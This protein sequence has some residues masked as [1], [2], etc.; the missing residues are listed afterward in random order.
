MG[1]PRSMKRSVLPCLGFLAL[2]FLFAGCAAS[3][4]PAG[5]SV[6]AVACR[7]A[8][9][10]ATLTLQYVNESVYA[11]GIAKSSHKLYLDG[12]PV[13]VIAAAPAVGLP[14]VKS[15]SQDVIIHFDDADRVRRL[16]ASPGAAAVRYRLE[17][18]LFETVGEEDYK[19]K[20]HSEGSLDLRPLAGK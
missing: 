18:T 20:L 16:A 7:P 13:G 14:P 3:Y 15:A 12:K 9:D 2:A 19:V 10:G 6:N 4:E 17:S 11:L 5:I 1:N 8:P